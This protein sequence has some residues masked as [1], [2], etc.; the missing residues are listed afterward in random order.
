MCGNNGKTDRNIISEK[1]VN[2]NMLGIPDQISNRGIGIVVKSQYIG[3][4]K[5]R[6]T[7]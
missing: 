1:V 3:K 7:V 4:N 2:R 6:N 5:K